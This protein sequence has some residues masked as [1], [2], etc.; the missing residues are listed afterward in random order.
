MEANNFLYTVILSI[1]TVII[2]I[3]TIIA[4]RRQKRCKEF[5]NMPKELPITSVMGLNIN[6]NERLNELTKNK[7]T[8]QQ[9]RQYMADAEYEV[10]KIYFVALYKWITESARREIEAGRCEA[11]WRNKTWRDIIEDVGLPSGL[12]DNAIENDYRF[13]VSFKGNFKQFKDALTIDESIETRLMKEQMA[14]FN[15][16]VTSKGNFIAKSK[17]KY[18]T[19]LRNFNRL[20]LNKLTDI[21]S[22]GQP[23]IIHPKVDCPS[24]PPCKVDSNIQNTPQAGPFSPQQRLAFYILLMVLIASI[25]AIVLSEIW[26][27]T[28]STDI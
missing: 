26:R 13:I 28:P 16:Y 3:V 18:L 6:Y 2:I 19:A 9:I 7:A 27:L 10:F 23:M 11:D 25:V 22:Y 17:D 4:F 1:F 20:N 5:G 15:R 21:E 12:F 24:C 14:R 8:I